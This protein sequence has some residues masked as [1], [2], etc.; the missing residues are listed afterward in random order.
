MKT[1]NFLF[2]VDGTLTPARQPIV[3]EFRIFFAKWIKTQRKNG[4]KVFLVTGSD[5]KK[6]IEQI[7]AALWRL[8]DGAYQNCGNQLYKRG[9]LIKESTWQISANLRLEILELIEKSIWYGTAKNNIEERIGM[10]NVS[11]IGRDCTQEQRKRYYA[12][13]KKQLE[14]LGIA[15][16]LRHKFNNIDVSI[17]GEVSIDVYQKGKDK[18]QILDDMDGF[19][20]FMGDRC[21]LG[22]NDHTI[23][24]KANKFHHVTGWRHTYKIL[25]GYQL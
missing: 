5:R 24:I 3:R 17:G 16:V 1:T 18:S 2:D 22:G 12:W 8:V 7:G 11:T 9:K 6:T 14:R 10:A 13:D 20:V 25:D 21:E 19:T 4:N 15:N 23:S